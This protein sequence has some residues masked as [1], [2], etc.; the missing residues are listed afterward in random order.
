MKGGC[1]DAGWFLARESPTILAWVHPPCPTVMARRSLAS[2]L[3]TRSQL[4]GTLLFLAFTCFGGCSPDGAPSFD[5][6]GA[7]FPAWLLCGIVGVAGAVAARVAFVS[8]RVANAL[9][10]QLAVC[11]AIGVITAVLFWLVGFGH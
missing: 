9:P 10:Y 3:A 5:L 2:E 4:R 7:F 1:C 6:F 8:G 11:V